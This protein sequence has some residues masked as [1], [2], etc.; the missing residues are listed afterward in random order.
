MTRHRPSRTPVF[1]VVTAGPAGSWDIELRG[2]L[3]RPT[4]R[5][6]QAALTDRRPARPHHWSHNAPDHHML[7]LPD[8]RAGDTSVAAG[9]IADL[10]TTPPHDPPAR[11]ASPALPQQA[12]LPEG[13]L[14]PGTGRHIEHLLWSWHGPFDMTRFRTA[15]QSVLDHETVLRTALMTGP[16]PMLLVHGR[17]TPD[18]ARRVCH[19]DDLTAVIEHDRRRGF[20]LRQPPALRLTL[21]DPPAAPTHR[22]A[23]TP[24]VRILLTYHRALIDHR[25]AHL[26]LRTFYRA[27]LASGSL[28]GGERRPDLRDY[29]AWS[30]AQD[31]D[32][33]R[34][35]WARLAPPPGAA[36]RPC[37]P[38]PDT[39]LTGVGRPRIRLGTADTGRLTR[40]AATWGAAD[41]TALQAVWAMLIYRAADTTGPLPVRFET[42]VPGR[43]IPL[44]GVAWTPGPLHN[45]QPISVE[46]DPTGTVPALLGR[47]RDRALDMAAYEWLPGAWIHSWTTSGTPTR[48]DTYTAFDH[49]P[50]PFEG[51]EDDLAAHGIR[52]ERPGTVPAYCGL[53][54]GLRAH[55]DTTGALVLTAI[56]DRSVLG[57]D[58]ARLLL[59]QSALLLHELPRSTAPHTTVA[60][61]LTL[62]DG[63]PVPR[64]AVPAQTPTASFTPLI[65][66]R[67]ARHRDPG[68]ICLVPPPQAP[69]TCYDLLTDTYDG[70]ERLVV[71]HPDTS[72]DDARH[73]LTTLAPG[74]NLRFA[75]YSGA[76]ARACVIA[77]SVAA[78]SRHRP[79]SVVLVAVSDD[80]REQARALAQAL[81]AAPPPDH[82]HHRSAADALQ[83]PPGGGT[84]VLHP[85]P[86]TPRAFLI[87]DP[88]R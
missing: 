8:D 58:E 77:R 87:R 45:L 42:T 43:G 49:P 83:A 65:T 71:L 20:D 1:A 50:V 82:P 75:G 51:L 67:A 70:P 32:S 4:L 63:S 39:A 48:A 41:S 17:A 56:H 59:T 18:I 76:G 30:A 21:L 54:L 35:H 13:D 27:Y 5:R 68:V 80:T 11:S 72:T 88:P 16:D 74:R 34:G 38:G 62:L 14:R 15:W 46:V 79:P 53:P 52:T 81:E 29:A 61:A 44:D 57:D 26:L 55:H 36:S 9:R 47:L 6:L 64:M 3:D 25:S 86:I 7:R 24:P 69:A 22:A 78:R 60:E 31:L 12:A 33:A 37:S 2:P 84:G 19:D 73:A 85:L 23:L 10:F 28:P 66:L 40:W